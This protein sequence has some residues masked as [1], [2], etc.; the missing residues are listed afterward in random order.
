M[1]VPIDSESVLEEEMVDGKYSDED[2]DDDSESGDKSR[3]SRGKWTQEEDEVLRSAVLTHGGRNWKKI[4]EYLDGRTDVQCLHRWQKVLRPGLV[5]GPWTQEEDDSVIQLVAKHGVKSWSFIARQLKGRLGKQCRERWYNHL[6]PSISKM[7]W[8]EEE[9]RLIVDCHQKYGNKW[10]VIAT[11]LPGRTDN[12]IK[13]RW[14]ST[15]QRLL[16]QSGD[17]TLRPKKT[18]STPTGRKTGG[19]GT[20]SIHSSRSLEDNYTESGANNKC[21]GSRVRS[22]PSLTGLNPETCVPVTPEVRG[23]SFHTPHRS[24]KSKESPLEKSK[25]RDRARECEDYEKERDKVIHE[26]RRKLRLRTKERSSGASASGGTASVRPSPGSGV[27]ISAE[28]DMTDAE[29]LYRSS[30]VVPVERISFENL[31]SPSILRRPQTKKRS[32]TLLD[33]ASTNSSRPGLPL[34]KKYCTD[35]SV[36]GTGIPGNNLRTPISDMLEGPAVPAVFRK[37]KGNGLL[38]ISPASSN[39]SSLRKESLRGVFS[40]ASNSG[41]RESHGQSLRREEKS[42]RHSARGM[43]PGKQGRKHRAEDSSP[44]GP[45]PAGSR[46]GR[47]LLKDGESCER[48]LSVGSTSNETVEEEETS[49]VRVAASESVGDLSRKPSAFELLLTTAHSQVPHSLP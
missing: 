29:E 4:S 15:L 1:V 11:F 35:S 25:D 40:Q 44:K 41:I 17:G 7:P 34:A 45:K 43:S 22:H 24:D 46:R 12:A 49:S 18:R 16:K 9:D 19:D 30:P 8:T 28:K 13:N 2:D 27:C 38:D 39:E 33:T 42:D 14:N 32:N 6:N 10:A 5:K 48:G 36:G 20:D 26:M 47:V 3:S 37:N 23:K 31:S 21:G